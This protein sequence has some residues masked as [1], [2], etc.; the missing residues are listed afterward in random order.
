MISRGELLDDELDK[1]LTFLDSSN[2]IHLLLTEVLL[3]PRLRET[4]LFL[5]CWLLLTISG[6]PPDSV[7][8]ETKFINI[9]IRE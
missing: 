5:L 9:Q 3:F 2:A 7:K 6:I 4:E 1:F 8:T